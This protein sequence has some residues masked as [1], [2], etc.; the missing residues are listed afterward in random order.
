MTTRVKRAVNSPV[1][2]PPRAR[3]QKPHVIRVSDN[4]VE[5]RMPS[6]LRLYSQN[7]VTF[8][9]VLQLFDWN[10]QHVR[11][12]IDFSATKNVDPACMSLVILYA[13]YLQF[14]NSCGVSFKFAEMSNSKISSVE[15][16][17]NDS[18]CSAWKSLTRRKNVQLRSNASIPT[19]SVKE[20]SDFD[21]VLDTFGAYAEGIHKDYIATMRYIISELT[22]NAIE[23]G[24]SMTTEA[25]GYK[26]IPAIIT[27]RHDRKDKELHLLVVDLGIGIKRHLEQAIPGFENDSSAIKKSLEPKISGTF[28]DSSA[29]RAKN[30]AGFGLYMSSSL[31]QDLRGDMYVVSNKG[32]VHISPRDITHREMAFEWPGTLVYVRIK[33]DRQDL[34]SLEE[35][36]SKIRQNAREE[37][38]KREAVHQQTHVYFNMK[39][40]FGEDAE[41]K[42]EAI[43]FRDRHLLPTIRDG[44]GVKLDFTDVKNSPHSFLNAMLADAVTELGEQAYRRIKIVNA[45]SEIRDTIDY[46]IEDNL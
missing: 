12:I 23:H 9:R 19:F 31:A 14:K 11:A 21:L 29:Y 39:N 4:T 3:K 17:W 30:N 26:Q 20:Y 15:K 28:G 46:I 2:S 8:E 45:L 41:N 27:F 40:Y 6:E 1:L 10:I 18:G 36:M 22:Y 34:L 37:I 25:S 44:K 13:S 7:L 5:V 24:Q 35:T 43:N 32:R 16:I 38:S 33:L 42:L